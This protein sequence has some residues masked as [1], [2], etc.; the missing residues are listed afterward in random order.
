MRICLMRAVPSTQ[1]ELPLGNCNRH[2]RWSLAKQARKMRAF[3]MKGSKRL[4]RN[5]LQFNRRKLRSEFGK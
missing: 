3:K 1:F 2:S 4:T 5:S